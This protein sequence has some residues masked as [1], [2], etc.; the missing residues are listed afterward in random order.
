[1]RNG[2]GGGQTGVLVR[3]GDDFKIVAWTH[4][5]LTTLVF[6]LPPVAV[7]V[8]HPEELA[9]RKRELVDIV[10]TGLV[11]VESTDKDWVVLHVRGGGGY[12]CEVCPLLVVVVVVYKSIWR[13]DAACSEGGVVEF[14]VG[15]SVG[16]DLGGCACWVFKAC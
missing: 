7:C 10:W 1:M 11:V 5:D 13:E 2:V 14:D 16:V 3:L 9:L 4:S 12:A 15:E 6:T 8:L